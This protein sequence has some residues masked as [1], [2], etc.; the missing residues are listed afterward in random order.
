VV[1]GHVAENCIER[2]VLL[3]EGEVIRSEDLPASIQLP[4]ESDSHDVSSLP[5]LVDGASLSDMVESYEKSILDEALKLNRGNIA[6]TARQLRS[7]PR[8]VSYKAKQ[9]SLAVS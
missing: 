8:I 7:T 5:K 4:G 2:A 9:Y 3:S 1:F 6:A